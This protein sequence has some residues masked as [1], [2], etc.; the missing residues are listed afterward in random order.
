MDK[1]INNNFDYVDLELPSGTLWATCNVGASKPSDSGLYFQWGDIRGY[2]YREVGYD[3][4][5]KAFNWKNYKWNLGDD[6]EDFTKYKNPGATLELEDDAAHIHMRGSWHI[7]NPEQIKELV[8]NTTSAWTT[9]DNV[10]G[11]S[12]ISK[13]DTSK[14]I[15]IPASGYASGVSIRNK[16]IEADIWSSMLDMSG[17]EYVQFLYFYLWGVNLSHGRARRIGMPVRGVIDG[18]CDDD[19][20]DNQKIYIKGSPDRGDEVIKTLTDLGGINLRNLNGESEDLYYYISPLSKKITIVRYNN[21]VVMSIL[22]EESY[23][24]IKL[25]KRE[26]W[27]DGTFLIKEYTGKKA[28]AVYNDEDTDIVGEMISYIY[29][30]SNGYATMAVSDSSNF[31]VASKDDIN[32]FQKL[33]HKY[34]KE[35]NFKNKILVDWRWK[36]KNNE[37]YWYIN[38]LG[39]ICHTSYN[40]FMINDPKRV[41]IGNCFQTEVDAFAMRDRIAK[42]L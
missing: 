42:L 9:L 30:D 34:R 2:T 17:V 31:K 5:Q 40:E 39:E 11:R 38:D 10:Y 25:P 32:D 7:P 29:V 22:K 13:K 4:G 15:F 8:N 6:G 20:K 14:S 28:Y 23:K 16:G 1:E 12:F 41:K 36:P 35:W 27:E 19:I 18:K 21:D 33:L 24:E 37:E 3:C 26:K